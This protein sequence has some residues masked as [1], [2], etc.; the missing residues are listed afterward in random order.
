MRYLNLLAEYRLC[1][2]IKEEIDAFLEG[3]TIQLRQS[4]R[5][6]KHVVKGLNSIIPDELL[7]IFDETELEVNIT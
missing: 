2:R 3:I 7:A 4:N 6:L 5:L 1:T